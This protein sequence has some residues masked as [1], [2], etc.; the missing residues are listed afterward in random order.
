MD[1][2]L[3]N[4]SEIASE[5]KARLG[6]EVEALGFPPRL[7]VILV[8]DNEESL[9]YVGMKQ[10]AVA[11]I[12]GECEV[13][14]VAAA[15]GVADLCAKVAVLNR[16]VRTHGILVQLPLPDQLVHEQETVL[17]ALDPG[18]DVDGFHPFNRGQLLVSQAQFISC[19]ALA[20]LEMLDRHIRV[21]GKHAVL[22]GDSFDLIQPLGLLLLARGCQVEIIPSP[23]EWQEAARRGDILVVE[24]GEPRMVTGD[25]IKPGSFVIDAGFHWESGKVCGNVD[26]ASVTGH[27]GWL[28]P[29]PGGMG[30]I[31]IAKLLEN[32]VQAAKSF[33]QTVAP[34]GPAPGALRQG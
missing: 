26:K 15:I 1:T 30:P 7:A 28:A 8:G 14:R 34:Y 10:K 9:H 5:I 20:T 33:E 16:D 13:L 3:I 17:A 23:V 24:K 32:L 31:L 27:A 21:D 12:G 2:R 29:V 4:G 19:A 22:I 25:V 6:R 11:A 18:K